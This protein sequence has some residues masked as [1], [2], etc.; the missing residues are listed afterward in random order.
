MERLPD[1]GEWH[2][3]NPLFGSN[4]PFAILQVDLRN[5]TGVRLGLDLFK[6]APGFVTQTR[7]CATQV[8]R[9][10]VVE[11]AFR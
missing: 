4:P 1:Y 7:T 10:D 2:L 3:S 11:S 5:Q 9:R 8:M 6:F